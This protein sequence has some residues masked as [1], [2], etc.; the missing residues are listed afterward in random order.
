MHQ[1]FSVNIQNVKSS[2]CDYKI[3]YQMTTKLPERSKFKGNI[4]I[5]TGVYF[6]NSLI[7]YNIWMM[8]VSNV[9]KIFFWF[10]CFYDDVLC[11]LMMNQC[12]SPLLR[13]TH[14]LTV[15]KEI[16]LWLALQ[17]KFTFGLKTSNFLGLHIQSWTLFWWQL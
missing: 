11:L 4:M 8:T 10:I 17:L 3:W 1:K 13:L 16:Y 7:C 6:F 2:S 9:T 15:Y 12:R 14:S 5:W